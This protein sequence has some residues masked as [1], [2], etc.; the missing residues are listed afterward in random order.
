M[1]A[2]VFDWNLPGIVSH[3]KM[4]AQQLCQS[5]PVI[6]FSAGRDSLQLQGHDHR[7]LP[8]V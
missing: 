7:V 3:A 4:L 6:K 1:V 5:K 2:E 8:W